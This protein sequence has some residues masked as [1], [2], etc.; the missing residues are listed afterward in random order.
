F[1]GYF[2]I[3]NTRYPDGAPQIAWINRTLPLLTDEAANKRVADLTATE[4]DIGRYLY[5]S[6]RCAVAHAFNNPVVDPDN[7]EDLLRLGAD[8]PVA[9]ALAEYLI[10]HEYGIRWE[11]SNR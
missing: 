9:K 10:E 7:P 4:N 8:M 2:K 6:G 5:V 1:L 3:I 11:F